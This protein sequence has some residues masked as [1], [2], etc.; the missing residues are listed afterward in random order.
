MIYNYGSHFIDKK[1]INYVK[2]SLLAK[3][4]T[5]GE[6]VK[7]FEKK[8][9]Q[10]L[11]CKYVAT[12][13]SGTAAIHLALSAINLKKGDNVIIPAVNFVASA[14]MCKIMGANIFFAD[15]DI[16]SGQMSPQNVLDCIKLNKLKKIKVIFSMYLGG[17]P[18]Y[19]EDFFKL[20]KK[21]K[22]FLIEDACHALG[23]TF[24]F[25]KKIYQVGSC[26]NSDFAIFS[27]HPVKSITTGE[28]GAVCTNILKYANK[29]KIYRS[30]GITSRKDYKYDIKNNFY[31]Y[32]LSD[33]NCALGLSQLSKLN[34][35]KNHRKKIVKYYFNE[36][37]SFGKSI[38]ILN[39]D[40]L[41]N[42]AWHLIILKFNFKI[43]KTSYKSL[44]SK[45]KKY[46]IIT[47]LHYVPTYRLSAFKNSIH[48]KKIY[49]NSEKYLNSCMSFPIH[50]NLKKKDVSKICLS[51]KKILF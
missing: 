7:K 32:R 45:L 29:I 47:Q 2:K 13:N 26:V 11:A 1:D 14:S 4:I 21:L 42:S 39:L 46:N 18:N 34:K 16:N 24:K 10:K 6:Y 33:I 37:K 25:Q 49:H 41:N 15:I 50:Y 12:C 28:G 44:F 30:H 51:L 35:F 8:L 40:S 23:S 36:L 48:S 31:N 9:K 38:E 20:K 3:N 5:N 43:L 27:F 19:A 17:A 22:C